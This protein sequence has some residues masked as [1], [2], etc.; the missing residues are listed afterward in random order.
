MDA[1]SKI[2]FL[3]IGTIKY[4]HKYNRPFWQDYGC[5]FVDGISDKNSVFI[6]W[7]FST[8]NIFG[9]ALKIKP[10]TVHYYATRSL[11]GNG[12]SNSNVLPLEEKFHRIC[13]LPDHLKWWTFDNLK[14]LGIYMLYFLSKE[15]NSLAL[16]SNFC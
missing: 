6:H 4:S 12:F 7:R 11:F 10:L 16:F 15:S 2:I 9:K 13:L 8:T 1:L 14:W 3:A 5:N